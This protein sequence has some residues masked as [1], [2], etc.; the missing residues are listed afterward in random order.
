MLMNSSRDI[1]KARDWIKLSTFPEFRP[2]FLSDCNDYAM[3]RQI[4]IIDVIKRLLIEW[5]IKNE[6]LYGI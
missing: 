2:L 6:P 1:T 4:K 3:Q 5:L